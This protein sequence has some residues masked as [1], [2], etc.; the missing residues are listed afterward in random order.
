[1][2][3]FPGVGGDINRIPSAGFLGAVSTV[4]DGGFACARALQKDDRRFKEALDSEGTLPLEAHERGQSVDQGL[5][6]SQILFHALCPSTI[7]IRIPLGQLLNVSPP[8]KQQNKHV[9]IGHDCVSFAI[10]GKQEFLGYLAFKDRL[11][12]PECEEALEMDEHLIYGAELGFAYSESSEKWKVLRLNRDRPTSISTSTQYSAANNN[13][14]SNL[15][16]RTLPSLNNYSVASPRDFFY[17]GVA[18]KPKVIYEKSLHLLGRGDKAVDIASSAIPQRYRLVDCK[19]LAEKAVLRICEFTGFPV[20]PYCAISYVWRNVR[21]GKSFVEGGKGIEFDV[22]GAEEADPI[23]TDVLYNACMASLRRGCTHLWLDRL[24]I[25]QT[26]QDDKPWQ[27]KEMYRMYQFCSV[28]VVLAGGLQYMV[29]LDEETAWIHRGWT[30]QEALAPPVV[31]VLFAWKLHSGQ[32]S[33]GVT[34]QSFERL[35]EV[36]PNQSAVTSLSLLLKTCTTNFMLFIPDGQSEPLKVE[37]RIFS[38]YPL[39]HTYN[40]EPFWRPTRNLFSPNVAALCIA[41]DETTKLYAIW[42]SALMRTSSRPVDMAF[43]IMSLFGV[44]LDPICFTKDDRL[45]A[46][47]ALAR[48]ILKKG[49]RATW[50]GAS[51]KLPP[52]KQLPTFSVFP[53]T[54]VAG[55]ALVNQQEVS[56]LMDSQ[57]HCPGALVPFPQG[58]MDKN[59]FFTFTAKAEQKYQTLRRVHRY[60][61]R[62]MNL[63]G[64][65]MTPVI[66]TILKEPH[67]QLLGWFI[68][69]VPNVTPSH[70]ADNIRAI[71]VIEHAPGKFHVHSYVF[72]SVECKSWVTGWEERS[73]CIGPEP[74]LGRSTKKKIGTKT[75]K[76]KGE[77]I[78]GLPDSQSLLSAPYSPAP[79]NP[80]LMYRAAQAARWAVPQHVLESTTG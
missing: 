30:L 15:P 31:E 27:I 59:G 78:R 29:S 56:E 66:R 40:D 46:T 71:L 13:Q 65:S 54:Q 77:V 53:R 37:N 8:K 41:M 33:A 16:P 47:I 45:S 38:G 52:C 14:L 23:S 74:H 7:S 5:Q 11:E 70:D 1:M 3:R 4:M 72:L 76:P 61:R 79:S 12:E 64:G 80:T 75:P 35:E 69:Y 67:S 28:C 9:L 51:F 73:F 50:L 6:G 43:S 18:T 42:K 25:M 48:A 20:V 58:S 62:K 17:Y 24:C 36:V 44:T 68:P 10:L 39:R 22:K 63:Y 57:Y 19:A 55:K 60:S 49:D 21:S 2:T 26:S 32:A 34:I